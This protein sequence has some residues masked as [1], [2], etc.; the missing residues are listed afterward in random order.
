M[1]K[2]ALQRLQTLSAKALDR[3]WDLDRDIDWTLP[4]RPKR[5]VPRAVVALTVSQLL[6][7]ERASAEM[8]KYLR[9]QGDMPAANTFLELQERDEQ[10]HAAAYERYLEVL[11]KSLPLLSALRKTLQAGYDAPGG[12]AGKIVACHLLLESE[13]LK[14]H[15]VLAENVACP[16]LD[17]IHAR[18]SPDEARHV[19][20]GKIVASSLVRDLDEKTRCELSVWA[21]RTCHACAEAMLSDMGGFT[22]LADLPFRRRIKE[23][24]ARQSRALLDIGLPAI[25]DTKFAA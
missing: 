13:A 2:F 17:A 18:I 23:G 20:F 24:W 4:I 15:E 8:A 7:G 5:F 11:G 19:A 25:P 12:T 14:I 3:Q 16:L 6:E 21:N 22:V 1:D 10:R 9:Q